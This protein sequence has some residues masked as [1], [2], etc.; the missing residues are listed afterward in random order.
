MAQKSQQCVEKYRWI[1]V[2]WGV[3]G[4]SGKGKKKERKGLRKMLR[5]SLALRAGVT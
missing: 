2:M 4:N 1:K 5:T 3:G